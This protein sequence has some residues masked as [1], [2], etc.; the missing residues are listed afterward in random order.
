MIVVNGTINYWPDVNKSQLP[1]PLITNST[2][3]SLKAVATIK[4]KAM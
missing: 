4:T 3:A 1:S 2:G